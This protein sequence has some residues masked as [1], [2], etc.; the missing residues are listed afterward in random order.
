MKIK[1]SLFLKNLSIITIFTS[2]NCRFTTFRGLL[3]EKEYMENKSHLVL[4]LSLPNHGL[5]SSTLEVV[6][7]TTPKLSAMGVDMA[8][9]HMDPDLSV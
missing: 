3:V 5:K 1:N 7:A 9:G 8:H 2:H 6:A 4:R